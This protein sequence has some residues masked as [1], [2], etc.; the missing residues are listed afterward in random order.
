MNPLIRELALLKKSR[1][2]RKSL[3]NFLSLFRSLRPLLHRNTSQKTSG[4]NRVLDGELATERATCL[5]SRNFLPGKGPIA[6][7]IAWI[8]RVYR[9]QL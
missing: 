6:A 8:S 2:N 4:N 1:S 5:G 7:G 9:L 3:E